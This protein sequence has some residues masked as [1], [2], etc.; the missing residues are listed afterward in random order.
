M[1]NKDKKLCTALNYNEHFYILASVVTG[2]ISFSDFAS[3]VCIPLE[4]TSSGV[5][6][7]I[8]AIT[9][10]IIK[11]KS[12]MK[13]KKNK[14]DKIVSLAKTNLNNI[15]VLIS[16]VLIESYISHDQFVKVNNVLNEYED[17]KKRNRKSNDLNSQSR[18]LT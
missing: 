1:S 11:Y 9:L 5:G 12:I 16:R 14:Y 8:C 6:I 17:M 10:G 4:I 2:C 15:E 7:K 18:I 13:K 3:L